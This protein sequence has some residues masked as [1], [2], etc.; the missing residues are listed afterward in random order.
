MCECAERHSLLGIFKFDELRERLMTVRPQLRFPSRRQ[1]TSL[2]PPRPTGSENKE[3]PASTHTSM[4][5]VFVAPSAARCT[6]TVL[7][8]H[9]AIALRTV[10]TRM[11]S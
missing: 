5:G 6:E 11:I 3:P 4:T 1:Q 9:F 7:R 2:I 10:P 8:S